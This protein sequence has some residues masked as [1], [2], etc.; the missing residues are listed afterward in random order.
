MN[1]HSEIPIIKLMVFIIDWSKVN[2]I[3]DI[4]EKEHVR[5]HFVCKGRGTASSEILD[6]LGI[7]S[8]EK[9]VVLCLEPD[10]QVACLL[11]KVSKK[12]GLHSPGTG[13]AFT[14]PLSG[15]NNPIA[16]SF[17]EELREEFS[18][19]IEKEIDRMKT[20]A[21]FDVILAVVNQGYSDELMSVAREAGATGGTIVNARSIAH[22]GIVKFFGISVQAERE[23]V[24][25]LAARE[26]KTEIMQAISHSYGVKSDAKGIVFSVPV[27]SMTGLDAEPEE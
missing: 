17:S 7:G 2:M 19:Q 25:I 24:T 26:T 9:A 15:I 4:F 3:T 16:Q 27:D 21:K 14:V 13:I 12:F 6:L 5:F 1:K 22:E 8:S 18:K 23:I 10:F 11:R 20:N